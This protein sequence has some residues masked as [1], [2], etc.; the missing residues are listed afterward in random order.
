MK[1]P[2]CQTE[3]TATKRHKLAVNYCPTCKGM[4]L[5]HAE[6]EQLE[7]EVFDFGEHAKGTLVFGS[8]PTTHPC[9]ECGVALRSFRYRF[10]ELAMELCVNQHGYWLTDDEDTRVLELMRNEE[11][12]MRR[13]LRAEDRW[14][15][16]LRQMRSHSFLSKVRDLFH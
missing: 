10:Y 5:E 11:R 15:A 1:C 14:A 8:Q 2:Q 9:P 7:D 6:L 12:E 4:W 3:L 16:T 13:K